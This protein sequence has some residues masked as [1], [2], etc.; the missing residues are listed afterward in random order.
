MIQDTRPPSH[1]V[2]VAGAGIGGLT[3]ALA[4]AARGFDV[5]VIE[6]RAEPA[7]SG[8]G[9]AL[10]ANS[11]RLLQRL[12]LGPALGR[13]GHEATGIEWRWGGSGRTLALARQQGTHERL[14][15]APALAVHRADLLALL[16]DAVA[17]QPRIR[18][19]TGDGIEA[20]EEHPDGV[21]LIS[22]AGRRHSGI[23][24]IGADGI[25]SRL[26]QALLGSARPRHAG[27]IAWRAVV[28][29]AALP[30]PERLDRFVFWLGPDRHV[31]AYPIGGHGRSGI[32]IAAFVK[33]ADPP[34][35]SWT[36][37]GDPAEMRAAYA[38]W[39]PRLQRL[40]GAVQRCH[41]L[42]LHEHDP[43]ASWSRG[44]VALL[45]DAC[46]AMLPHAGQGAGA[47]IEDAFVLAG[48]LARQPGNVPAA[49]AAYSAARAPRV[50]RIM[51]TVRALGATY[52]I[53]NPVR[54]AAFHGVLG[55]LTRVR[56]DALQHRF[57]WLYGFDA[58]TPHGTGSTIA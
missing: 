24:A 56:P 42:S 11:T 25:H 8:T 55:L 9:L 40:L 29:P 13:I 34:E 32:N 47:A 4:L 21:T 43:P 18:L 37:E 19:H 16:L 6:Q 26:R 48:A 7:A 35:A 53:A 58:E 31:L 12:G 36:R 49:L 44:R 28:P 17:A 57:A 33:V 14:F 39:E 45:G 20:V 3:T 50:A 54:R 27:E 52:R 51:H 38:G 30:A 23:A 15:G 10:Y 2:L 5:D 22:A 1:T 46:H 41:V